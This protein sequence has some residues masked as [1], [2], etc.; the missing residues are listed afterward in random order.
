MIHWLPD[1]T[2]LHS[3]YSVDVQT[4]C[5]FYKWIDGK[6]YTKSNHSATHILTNAAGWFFI[7]I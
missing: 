3:T 5:D 7:A 4:A 6:T 1:L 2:V